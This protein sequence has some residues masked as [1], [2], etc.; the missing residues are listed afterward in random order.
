[1]G[2]ADKYR[3]NAHHCQRMADEALTPEDKLNWLNMAETW[4]GMIPGRQRAPQE[5][6]EEVVRDQ[7]TRQE[8]SKSRH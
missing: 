1:M 5:M 4:L 7:G 2:N 8:P 3:A 6:F